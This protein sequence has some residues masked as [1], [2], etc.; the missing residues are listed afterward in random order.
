MTI[1]AFLQNQW[2]KNPESIR[3][4]YERNPERREKL[5]KL[6]L[7][8]GCLTGKRLRAAFGDLCNE[9]IWENASR[10]I[11][12]KSSAN[13]KPD[14]AHIKA[15]L[16]K[17]KPDLILLFGKNATHGVTQHW[18]GPKIIYPHPANRSLV[19]G[20]LREWNDTL[21]GMLEVLESRT[22]SEA[23]KISQN[24]SKR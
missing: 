9:I 10:E 8:A 20:N 5:N 12:G 17:H 11:G 4:M 7:F 2:F 18:S 1:V 6:F 21:Q 19:A 16:D 3:A 14:P 22:N 15:V 24:I 23:P 13:F